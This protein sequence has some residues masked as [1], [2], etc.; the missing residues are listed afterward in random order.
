MS[1]ERLD[2]KERAGLVCGGF[3][4]LLVAAFAAYI[5][6]ANSKGTY[7]RYKQSSAALASVE[8]DME[9]ARRQRRNEQVRIASGAELEE[10]LN[11]RDKRFDLYSHMNGIIDQC[12]LRGRAQ[13]INN[14][15]TRSIRGR[16]NLPTVK[17]TLAKVSLGELVD[18]LHKV[19]ASRS[20][21]VMQKCDLKPE[22]KEE[23]L[24]CDL[25][26]QTVKG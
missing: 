9:A 8:A 21:I 22:L 13:L 18:F 12:G 2:S 17:L 10:R 1:S 23:G 6:L 4:L 24:H 19:Y 25:V 14:P 15:T 20:L 3:A 16:D 7:K 11:G 26:F 5:G